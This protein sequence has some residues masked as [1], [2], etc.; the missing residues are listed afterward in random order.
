MSAEE[1]AQLDAEDRIEQAHNRVVFYFWGVGGGAGGKH[2][3]FVF[4]LLGGI[5]FRWRF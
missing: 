5:I 2:G 3:R 1:L 4:F